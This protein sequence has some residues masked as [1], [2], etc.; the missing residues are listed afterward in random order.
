MAELVDCNDRTQGFDVIL[1]ALG[2][3]SQVIYQLDAVHWCV[4]LAQ[5]EA[6]GAKLLVGAMGVEVVYVSADRG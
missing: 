6:R 1:A 3:A 4:M 2:I 5:P